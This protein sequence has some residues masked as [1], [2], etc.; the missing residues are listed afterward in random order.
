MKSIQFPVS[1]KFHISSISNDFT[2]TD[3]MGNTLAYVRQKMFKFKEEI[4]VFN[5]KSRSKV[6]YTI[7][8]DKWLDFNTAYAF[9]DE[10]GNNLGKVARKGWKSL[11]KA[12]YQIIDQ[13]N[14]L[15]FTISEANPW[16]KIAD[17]LLGEIPVL[18]LLTGYMF[19]PKYKV[20]DVNFRTVAILK[21]IPSMF[22]RRFEI[23][24]EGSF[25]EDDSERIILSLMM[26]VLLERRRG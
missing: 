16:S 7:N 8:A 17:S 15:Q 25:D 3:A 21:K 24:K 12:S 4:Q 5:D 22:G 6:N 26:M 11:W 19:H 18:G 9:K 2:A 13:H 23:T 20:E 10:N 1:L 14:N